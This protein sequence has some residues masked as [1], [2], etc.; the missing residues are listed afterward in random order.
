VQ[1]AN[2][3]FGAIDSAL[4]VTEGIEAT[5]AV[6]TQQEQLSH[7]PARSHGAASPGSLQGDAAS[8]KLYGSSPESTTHV[9]PSRSRLAEEENKPAPK[10][11]EA[12]RGNASPRDGPFAGQCLSLP[13]H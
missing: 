11:S 8:D 5:R 9:P 13:V 3:I 6:L 1:E 2:R 4:K 10:D 7:H 12:A